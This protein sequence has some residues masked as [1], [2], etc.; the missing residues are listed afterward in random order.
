MEVFLQQ[1]SDSFILNLP[2]NW[3]DW[4]LF[5]LWAGTLLVLIYRYSQKI[6][7]VE[8]NPLD[9]F[10][11]IFL[12]IICS[13]LFRIDLFP[14]HIQI[15][16]SNAQAGSEFFLILLQAIPWIAA[17][18]FEKRMLSITLALISSMIF[19]GFFGHNIF[20]ILL[21]LSVAL[22]FN[23][24]LSEKSGYLAKVKQ[25]PLVILG[26]AIVCSF[27]LFFLERFTSSSVELP[28]RLDACLH[29]GWIFY[30]SR[31]LEL[32]AAGFVAE[33]LTQKKGKTGNQ[34]SPGK[35]FPEKKKI[36]LHLMG[37]FYL[38]LIILTILW[39][40][41]RI[42]ALNA[43]KNE[44][45]GRIGILDT[46]IMSDFTSNAI[47]I[48]Q[49]SKEILLSGN[50]TEIREQIKPLFQPIQNLDEFYLFN[51]QGELVFSYPNVPEEALMISDQ[52]IRIFQNTL[53]ENT[54][55]AAFSS[56]DAS[57]LF[58]STLYPVVGN[59]KTIQGIVIARVDI[60]NNPAFLPLAT[61][62]QSYQSEGLQ[63]AF[64]NTLISARVAWNENSI[65]VTD[66]ASTAT[67]LYSA[68]GLEGWGI[69]MSL[70]KQAFLTDFFNDFLP[71]L[72]TT[73]VCIAAVSGFYFLKW[74]N[75]EKA[76]VSL[77]TRFSADGSESSKPERAVFF[78]K[79]VREFMEILK[80]IFK[81]MDKRFQE[82]QTLLDL[83]HSYDNSIL[84]HSLVEKALTAFSEEDTLFIKV[85]VENKQGDR[86]PDT[87]LLSLEEGAED[88]SYLNE[89]INKIVE[90]QDQLVIGNTA[91][92]HQLV[93]AIG[94]PFP[95]ALIV[96]RFSIDSERKGTLISAYRSAHEFSKDSI[97]AFNQK[98]EAF[99]T[100][101]AAI[102][103]L[104]QWLMEK[105]ILSTLFDDLNF[106]LFI[107]MN[108]ELLYGNKAACTFLKMDD[109]EEH[110]SI[111]K[112][113][114]E[115]EIYNIMLRNASQEKSVVTKE[116]PSGEK[117]E[118]DILNSTDPETGQISV[119]L[120]K[121]ITSEKKREEI[122]HDFVNMLSHD[123]RSPITVMQGYSK[124]LPMV[125]ELNA[126]QQDYLEKIKNGL[127]TI[128]ALVEGILT[129][130]RIEH[131]M[132]ISSNEIVLP[133]MIQNILSQLESLANQK[134][135]KIALT[136]ITPGVIIQGDAVLLKQALYNIIHNAI[137]FSELDGSVEIK[138]IENEE[139][140]ALEIRDS[141][142]GIAALDIPF[143]FEK[144]YHPKAGETSTEKAGGTGL[145]IAKFIINAHRGNIAVESELGKGAIFRIA[146][147]K[148]ISQK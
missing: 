51:T 93:R 20:F 24:F 53:Q 100:Q 40:S 49:L 73:L 64:V 38:S 80:A 14:F 130:D 2:G 147:P 86:I 61:L 11:Y 129:E 56:S 47:R 131:G 94:K 112:R 113:V 52:E 37:L 135:V 140:V 114:H 76:V 127:E 91:R 55:Q 85:L 28:L 70:N 25:H 13:S 67:S 108:K 89:Q 122:T 101:M 16:P 107:F 9:W 88:F 117:Y 138:L 143:I 32:M 148:T 71:Y 128:T 81:K 123:L 4:F 41:T 78:P 84:F 29:D 102:I 44:I 121:D 146:L 116:M 22:L 62:I 7:L 66:E 68:I 77:S 96:T 8:T 124:M 69:E 95:Q 125:G 79:I 103:H 87:Y 3:A 57:N 6:K 144:Y 35:R 74:A 46:A 119:L 36:K 30:L 83:W 109:E 133:N 136:D 99:Y 17:A 58:M 19:S 10:L 54:I 59:D 39:N 97:A 111:E 110:T 21:I 137:K 90:D 5:C 142:P 18:I 115:N 92:F 43:W 139:D 1:I 23:Y 104:Q 120:L 26:L 12:A 34:E 82:T 98:T 15:F 50:S 105:K 45:A 75:L 134:R 126:T 31:I 65:E 33:L 106:P 132:A 63:V 141:G 60:R 42:H 27:P 118:I 145:Y 72:V 48:D